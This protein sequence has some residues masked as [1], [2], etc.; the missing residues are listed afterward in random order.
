MM[1]TPSSTI[2][3]PEAGISR[4]PFQ[5]FTD[6]ALYDD[7][8]SRLFR[9]PIW[10]FVALDIEI[11][12]TGDFKTSWI[13]DTPVVAVRDEAGIIRVFVNRCAHRGATLCFAQTGNKKDFTCVYHNWRYDLTGALTSVAFQHGI[14]R[15]GGMPADFDLAQHHLVAL[16]VAVCA[17]LVFATFS[18]DAPELADYLG[19]RMSAHINR[20]FNRPVRILGSYSQYM[21]N[22]WKLYMEN[23]KDSYHAS[24]L[25]LFFTTFKLNRLSMQGGLLLDGNGGHHI[26]YSKSAS[27]SSAG[28]DYESGALRAQQDDFSLADPSLLT[29]WPEF[30]DGIT[31]AIQGIFPNLIVQQIQN[32]LAVRL[33]VPR[34]PEGC[35]LFWILFGYEDDTPAQADARLRQSNL[36]GPA[37]LVSMEDGIIGNFVQRTIRRDPD[38][39][40]VLE[41]GGREADDQESRI[42]EASVRGFWQAYRAVVG[43]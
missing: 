36:V 35:E 38:R 27:D 41:M 8:Q 23:V 2:K 39:Q 15:A 6:P 30:E 17:G 5:V 34:G 22:N 20:I 10:N 28:T 16:R 4:V 7:E 13:G 9:G 21:K 37:G 33:L 40:A 31:H 24:L 26:S 18:D 19:P 3:W 42:S 43:L 12:N 11:P 32:S 1:T 29:A 14:R 25:H